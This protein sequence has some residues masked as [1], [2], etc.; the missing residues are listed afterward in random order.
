VKRRTFARRVLGILGGASLGA[1]P[2]EAL[3]P[4]VGWAFSGGGHDG[5]EWPK[6][7]EAGH[8][9]GSGSPT[10]VPTGAVLDLTVNGERLNRTLRELSRFGRTPEGG[11]NRVA[12]SDADLEARAYVQG[13]MDE[14]GLRVRVDAAGN[15][16]GRRGGREEGLPPILFGSHIDSVPHGGNYDGQV[17][18]MGAVEA[19][20]RLHEESVVTRHPL[21]VVI[22]SNEEGGKTGSRAMSGEVEPP[23]MELPTASGY[24]IG[25]GTARIGGDPGRL[26]EVVRRPG[27]VAAFLEL[28]VEQG[29][30]LESRGIQIG[31]VEG[32]VGIRRWNVEV[33]G[34]ANHA[35]TTPMDGRRDALV[36]AARF[37]DAVHR[38]AGELPGRQVATVG[39]IEAFPGAPNVIPGRATLSLE[40]RDLEMARIDEILGLLEGEAA[41]IGRET[42]TRFSF[43]PFYLSAAA[44]TH[45]RIR[46]SVEEEA[47][48][49]G[50]STLRMPSGAGH[51]AQSLALLA[52]VGMIFVP[53]VRGISHSPEELTHPRD[54][55]NGANVL[56][57]TL[58]ALD[59]MELPGN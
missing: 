19:A 22:F 2:L 26:D 15:L 21:E 44:P 40:I 34:F 35:G 38:T 6:R 48:R 50:L 45:L 13:L 55:V 23:E 5:E 3:A 7:P 4:R 37:V 31:V 10:A 17:G 27:E 33:Q 36:A 16:I 39:R 49:L 56:L 42:D 51:D 47:R 53:S 54:V 20:R 24:T 29:A 43:T 41:R 32:I 52:P 12:F 9:P 58:L 11:I 1:V 30:V 8:A 57:C 18:A 59:R 28:H 25:E 46:D 14:A